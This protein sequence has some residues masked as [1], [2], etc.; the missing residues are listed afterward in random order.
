MIDLYSEYSVPPRSSFQTDLILPQ[1]PRTT[2]V[3]SSPVE[4]AKASELQVLVISRGVW[5]RILTTPSQVALR[6]VAAMDLS[7]RCTDSPSIVR[8]ISPAKPDFS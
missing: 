8:L 1:P 4:S 3:S 6:S 2:R 5:H 7:L